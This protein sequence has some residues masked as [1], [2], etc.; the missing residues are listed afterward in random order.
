RSQELA[1]I[2]SAS[3]PADTAGRVTSWRPISLCWQ[4]RLD[5]GERGAPV[6]L[7]RPAVRRGGMLGGNRRLDVA[8]YAE[9][10]HD[11]HPAGL[12]QAYQVVENVVGDRLM[13]DRPVAKPVH[14]ELEAFE[15][16][17][18]RLRHV[19]DDERGEVWKA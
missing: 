17:D 13:A 19:V 4:R 11:A 3:P 9:L 16:H 6:V 12:E 2:W 10:G 5:A 14:V 18:A 15:L 1:R 8:A 7:A